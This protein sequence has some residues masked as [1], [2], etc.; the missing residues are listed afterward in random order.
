LGKTLKANGKII[1]E[2]IKFA[3][4]SFQ[5]AKGLMFE[6]EKKFN[7]GLIFCLPEKS[8]V[9]A[10]IHMLFVFFPITVIWLDEQK[11]IVDLKK[12]TPFELNYTPKKPAKYVI[13]LK[14]GF[15]KKLKVGQKLEWN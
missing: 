5:R 4:T 9:L 15:E 1:A 7:Y 11:K 10:S 2:K 12:M 14:A 8:K 6:D 3:K 13:E